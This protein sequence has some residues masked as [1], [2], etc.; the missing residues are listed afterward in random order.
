MFGGSHL[1]VSLDDDS[2]W[3]KKKKNTLLDLND[4]RVDV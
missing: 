4:S 3:Q 1:D 2:S